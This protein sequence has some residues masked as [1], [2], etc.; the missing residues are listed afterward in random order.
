M[1][2]EEKV[3]RLCPTCLHDRVLERTLA[4]A[5]AAEQ[6]LAEVRAVLLE[7]GQDAGTARRRALAII[8]S[9]EKEAE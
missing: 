7:G 4:R 9:D 6:E 1:G 2:G 5:E 8:G 3:T